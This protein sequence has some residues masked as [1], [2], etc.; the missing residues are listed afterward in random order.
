M[1]GTRKRGRSWKRLASKV[2]EASKIT[3]IR[4]KHA[5]QRLKE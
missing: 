3:G 1:E 4:N 5:S 2:E